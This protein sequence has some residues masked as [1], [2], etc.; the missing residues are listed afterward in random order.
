MVVRE[1]GRGIDPALVL[2]EPKARRA[3]PSC[4]HATWTMRRRIHVICGGGYMCVKP[5]HVD[6]RHGLQSV[7][8]L[9]QYLLQGCSR[10]GWEAG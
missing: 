8:L 7:C 3:A 9:L 6:R 1:L 2:C 5:S 4:R 10:G